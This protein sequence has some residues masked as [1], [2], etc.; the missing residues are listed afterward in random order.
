M[1]PIRRNVGRRV[2]VVMK[3][4]GSK[5]SVSLLA[6][7][8]MLVASVVTITLPAHA[9]TNTNESI[10]LSPAARKFTVNAGDVINDKL[11]IVNDGGTGYDFLVYARP[12]SIDV[13][14]TQYTSPDFTN[15]TKNGDLYSW[16]KF[17][18]AKYYLDAGKSMDIDY[19]ISVPATASPGGHYGVIFAEVQP[20]DTA[21]AG[22]TV[23]RKKRVGS[24]MYAT[25]NGDVK[26]EGS[27]VGS[28]NSF[29]QFEPPLHATVSAKN[30][31]NTHF[32]DT[33]Q[34][35]VRDVFG[36]IKYQTTKDF[37]ILPNTTRVMNLNWDNASWFGLYRVQTQQKFLD[38]TDSSEAYV[39]I[40][41]RFM[42]ALFI[43]IVIAGGVYALARRRK[44]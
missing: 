43:V 13:N 16:V 38:K 8:L 15:A 23:V 32:T 5:R 2:R 10:T 27:I 6:V 31:G 36:N 33:A 20:S 3:Y 41:P 28:Q 26:L 29:W 44:K 9:Q 19:S 37:Q 24:L 30:T 7:I 1:N 25:V 39:L 4:S 11:T 22:N 21:A 12:Y 14:D 35:V 34:L 40:M 17:P 42:P 18:Q